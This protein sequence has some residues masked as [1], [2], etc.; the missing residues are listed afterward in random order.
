MRHLFF[1]FFL[2]SLYFPA[3]MNSLAEPTFRDSI[4]V[5]H[6][7]I[8]LSITDFKGK[9]ITGKT[10]ITYHYVLGPSSRFTFDLLGL[11][12]DSAASKE[13]K[14]LR[15]YYDGQAVHGSF[16][17]PRQ[18]SDTITLTVWYHGTPQQDAKW[19]GFYFTEDEAYN[20]GVGMSSVPPNFGRVWFPCID[21]F[22]DRATYEFAVTVPEGY[23]AVCNGLLTNHLK[24]ANHT[25]TWCWALHQTIPT[26]LASLAAGKYTAI[27]GA[28]QNSERRIPWKIFCLPDDREKTIT[29]FRNLADW[30]RIFESKFGPYQWDRI[31]FVIVPFAGGA[32][33]HATNIAISRKTVDGSLDWETL[34]AHELSHHWFGDLVTCTSEADMWLNEGWASYCEAIVTEGLYGEGAF[35]DYVRK[36]QLDV[37][38]NTHINDQGYYPVYGIPHSLTYGS[39]VYDKGSM[40]VHNLRGTL[41]DSLFFTCVRKYLDRFRFKHCSVKEFEQFMSRTSG[42]GLSDFFRFW[43]YGT[44]FNS[45]DIDS[46][47]LWREGETWKA[48]F[49]MRQQLVATDTYENHAVMEIG[50][51]DSLWKTHVYKTFWSGEP[52]HVELSLPFCPLAIYTDPLERIAD[53]SVDETKIIEGGGDHFFRASYFSAFNKTYPDSAWVHVEEKFIPPEGTIADS[54]DICLSPLRFWKVNVLSSGKEELSGKFFYTRSISELPEDATNDRLVLLFRPVSSTIWQIVPFRTEGN[55]QQGFLEAQPLQTGYYCIG[56]KR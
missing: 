31:G 27:D 15:I 55:E 46:L 34:Y 42:I 24:N 38:V 39:T 52:A 11:T 29:S 2:G 12:V 18:P 40:M 56:V 22:T 28:Y 20:Y 33:E 54:S 10:E 7:K 30:V 41:G 19:G 23:T 8:N 9:K 25:E 4:D 36:N 53:A 14:K 26:Y 21:N 16:S 32:M 43:I 17:N 1:L 37:L 13:L 35:R 6:Y 51:I 47:R 50:V 49:R 3:C 5:I 48:T 45:I 44:G